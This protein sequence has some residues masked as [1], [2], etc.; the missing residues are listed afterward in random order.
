MRVLLVS[1]YEL[2]HQ[3]LHVASPAAALERAG[4]R[5]SALD[6]SVE[7][8]DPQLI[9]DVDAVAVSVPM[10]T[11][12]RLALQAAGLV[13]EQ[14]P[15]LPVCLYGLYAG[16][17]HATVVGTLAD[18]VI[19]GEYE[20]ALLDWVGSVDGHGSTDGTDTVA[21][22]AGSE[23]IVHLGRGRF[24][25]PA[26]HLLP[27]L[28][29]Y[30]RL[31]DGDQER[32]VGYVEASHGCTFSCRHCPVPTVYG[33]RIRIVDIDTILADIDQLVAA[34]ATHIT[35]GD[36]DFL[37]GVHHSRRVVAALHERHPQ[38]SFD[39]TT[40]V[41]LILRH[42]DVWADFADA[43]CRFVVS[44]FETVDDHVLEILDK[45]HTRAD[46][47]EAT[48]VLRSHGIE[49]RPSLLPFTPWTTLASLVELMDFVADHDLIGNVDPVHYSI[50][51]L[52]PEDSLL[53]DHP[54]MGPHL[55]RY[56]ADQLG[57]EWSS[58]D[59]RTDE[60]Q[61][62]VAA[63]VERAAAVDQPLAT[64]FAEVDALVRAAAGMEPR[65]TPI[66]AEAAARAQSRPRLT[67]A[68]FCCAEPTEMQ[69]KPLGER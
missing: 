31:S 8:W 68:W 26:R 12:M 33:G 13:R 40:K 6:L 48:A 54:A 61:V 3:P 58:A 56:V 9:D 57:Y 36:P 2:G 14:R 59:P 4:R 38:L 52:V 29:R 49:V 44:A 50:R 53:V 10:H 25:V 62:R 32:L 22:R 19:S 18:R 67:E 5:V 65:H 28:E 66:D 46:M 35:F 15:G 64:T 39:C 20:P 24:D 43:G 16:T 69:R 27:P 23:Q 37:N 17:S 34:G 41:E 55:G 30:A 7:Q 51:L 42:R 60:L 11:A 21:G 1:T 45:G 63:V 47:A